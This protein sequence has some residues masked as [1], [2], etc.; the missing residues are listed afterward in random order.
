M[1]PAWGKE[2]ARDN[3]AP[4]HALLQ[5]YCPSVTLLLRMPRRSPSAGPRGARSRS[6]GTP[7]LPVRRVMPGSASANS[8][9]DPAS[10][11]SSQPS[12]AVG[13]SANAAA[14]PMKKQG[15]PSAAVLSSPAPQ[16][17]VSITMSLLTGLIVIAVVLGLLVLSLE[18][19]T[20]LSPHSSVLMAGSTAVGYAGMIC[21]LIVVGRVSDALLDLGLLI[22]KRMCCCL[23]AFAFFTRERV[24]TACL[25]AMAATEFAMLF[26][27]TAWNALWATIAELVFGETLG[28][29]GVRL[30]GLPSH[31]WEV[32]GGFAAPLVAAHA[33]AL[34]I[35]AVAGF[36]AAILAIACLLVSPTA[37]IAAVGHVA[38]VVVSTVVAAFGSQGG[39]AAAAA[40]VTTLFIA[41]LL[42]LLRWK[43]RAARGERFW[44]GAFNAV[45]EVTIATCVAI[46]TTKVAV[47]MAALAPVGAQSF[48]ICAACGFPFAIALYRAL[49]RACDVVAISW[50]ENVEVLTVNAIAVT[51][52]WAA[53]AFIITGVNV[54]AGATDNIDLL[55]VPLSQ[56]AW[57]AKL[58]LTEHDLKRAELAEHIVWPLATLACTGFMALLFTSCASGGVRARSTAT[59]ELM[60]FLSAQVAA[61]AWL[62][63]PKSLVEQIGAASGA[64][65]EPAAAGWMRWTAT[66]APGWAPWTDIARWGGRPTATVPWHSKI[67]ALTAP[68]DKDVPLIVVFTGVTALWAIIKGAQVG[69]ACWKWLFHG[70]LPARIAHAVAAACAMLFLVSALPTAATLMSGVVSHLLPEAMAAATVPM[71]LALRWLSPLRLALAVMVVEARAVSRESVPVVAG[72]AQAQA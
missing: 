3:F 70:W 56:R 37:S 9:C 24:L 2:F 69:S 48:V 7:Q 26:V 49:V 12:A 43:V 19:W 42:G 11:V 72:G 60:I 16:S 59:A 50:E 38:L 18:P 1:R 58:P 30:L 44:S 5:V 35:A 27:G 46:V 52:A 51:F 63:F 55:S 33:P 14:L 68:I 17:A 21:G 32:L 62:F 65:L 31:P 66:T 57:T 40:T 29:M 41:V 47:V 67:A 61:V 36:A 13:G 53:T 10:P 34:C 15:E 20:L 39:N 71:L 8:D 45:P 28:R 4:I 6:R 25:V 54:V 22:A 64:T 23:P